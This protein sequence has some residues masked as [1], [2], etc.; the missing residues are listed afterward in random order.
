MSYR[1][2]KTLPGF[3]LIRRQTGLETDAE[4]EEFVGLMHTLARNRPALVELFRDRKLTASELLRANREERLASLQ[5]DPR[6]LMDLWAAMDSAWAR[7]RKPK[8]TTVRRYRVSAAKLRR[9]QPTL[10]RVR[11]LERVDW[12]DVAKR[13]PGSPSDWMAFYRMLS[14]FLTL[15]FGGKRTGRG[16]PFRLQV[17]D[18]LP[19]KAET[20]RV[21]ALSP[22]VFHGM[23]ARQIPEHARPCY[24]A[25]A[26]TGFRLNEYLALDR[27]HLRPAL[28]EVEVPGTK[29]AESAA[30]IPVDPSLWAWLDKAVPSPLGELQLRRYWHR[31]C[32]AEGLASLVPDPTG[33]ISPKT[34]KV[35]LR[36]RGPTLHDLRHCNGQ[37]ATNAGAQESMVQ[38]YLRHTDPVTT[39][40]YTMQQMRNEMATAVARAM[41]VA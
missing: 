7:H 3:G 22:A 32:L 20:K 17:M 39:R 25:L 33:R 26:I 8:D 14:T 9:L 27:E 4:M 30:V 38:A 13:W 11:D 36:Y 23:M 21:P 28:Y 34:K 10:E 24:Y 19:R 37:W 31:A 40:R 18:L 1:Y 29:T 5:P 2:E 15:H 41:G 16:H 35:R 12:D 6:V